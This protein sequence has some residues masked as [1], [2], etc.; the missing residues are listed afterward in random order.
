[1]RLFG[2]FP[3]EI[4]IACQWANDHYSYSGTEDERIDE[5]D[6]TALMTDINIALKAYKR[7]HIP[8]EGLQP[9]GSARIVVLRNHLRY[10]MFV[11]T[12]TTFYDHVLVSGK[13]EDVKRGP[14]AYRFTPGDNEALMSS[15]LQRIGGLEPCSLQIKL[16]AHVL[17]GLTHGEFTTIF[18]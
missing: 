3:I 11:A 13:A 12:L 4:P 17:L 2:G 15:V 14:P 5:M 8:D 1:M 16:D 9:M 10:A 7:D 6:R 18:A